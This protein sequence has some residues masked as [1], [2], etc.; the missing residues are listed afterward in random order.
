MSLINLLGISLEKVE[1]DAVA[2]KRLL[3]AAER[4]IADAQVFKI[5]VRYE[6]HLLNLLGMAIFPDIF[7]S[8][9]SRLH[10]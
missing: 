3:A 2:I 4:N 9:N 1:P 5:R 10:Q 8:L 7:S 6:W